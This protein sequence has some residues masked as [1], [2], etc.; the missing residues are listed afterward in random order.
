MPRGGGGVG[1]SSTGAEDGV[2]EKH[3]YFA[4]L[5][6]RRIGAVQGIDDPVN[7]EAQP[8][9]LKLVVVATKA[10]HKKI[11]EEKAA[12]YATV[13]SKIVNDTLSLRRTSAHAHAGAGRRRLMS[14]STTK[15]VDTNGCAALREGEYHLALQTVLSAY[16]KKYD[17]GANSIGIS[18]HAPGCKAVCSREVRVRRGSGGL[19]A[20][21]QGGAERPL[22]EVAAE[23]TSGWVDA[24]MTAVVEGGKR[25]LHA[26]WDVHIEPRGAEKD[27]FKK[28]PALTREGMAYL[29]KL[30]G[31]WASHRQPSFF[32][33]SLN[34]HAMNHPIGFHAHRKLPDND[35][36]RLTSS[37]YLES[38]KVRAA[39][40]PLL[41]F[42]PAYSPL[43][44]RCYSAID[45]IADA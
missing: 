13:F 45:R 4:N 6:V 42:V 10:T 1:T 34:E 41:R 9:S 11:E 32:T 28:M 18:L 14:S 36:S 31:P 22:S 21:A 26:R 7:D 35:M 16:M 2:E 3:Y 17:L 24:V 44:S 20:A 37:V 29:E 27:D 5:F 43:V 39:A 8:L 40:L 38:A 19:V 12:F 23:E 25:A 33:L 30:Y 15:V